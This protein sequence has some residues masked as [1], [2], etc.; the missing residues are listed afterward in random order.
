MSM[1]NLPLDAT[2]T[3]TETENNDTTGPIGP[4]SFTVEVEADAD[5][6]TLTT[7]AI[8]RDEDATITVSDF[9]CAQFD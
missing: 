5:A 2:I 3:V 8:T 1:V 4:V 9:L 7:N 6:V